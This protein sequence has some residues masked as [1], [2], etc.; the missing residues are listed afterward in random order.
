ML[1]IQR[2]SRNSR[3]T[4]YQKSSSMELLVQ[5][6]LSCH[7]TLNKTMSVRML[8]PTTKIDLKVKLQL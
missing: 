4:G 6:L 2:R 8:C 1:G 3:E 7:M 5:I